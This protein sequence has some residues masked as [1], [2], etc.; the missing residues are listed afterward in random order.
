MMLRR[1]TAILSVLSF[2]L[3]MAGIASATNYTITDL[4]TLS[5]GTASFATGVNSS[6]TVVGFAD[7]GGKNRAAYYQNGVWTNIGSTKDANQNTFFTAI[8]DSGLMVGWDRTSSLAKLGDSF[9]YQVG[10]SITS[11]GTFSGVLNGQPANGNKNRVG[12]FNNYTA[13]GVNWTGY[14]GGINNNGQI[15]GYWFNSSDTATGH[16]FLMSG[17]STTE[18]SV[19]FPSGA[20]SQYC[21]GLNDAGVTIGSYLTNMA[22]TIGWY[23]DGTRH[24]IPYGSVPT[25]IVGNYVVGNGASG[26]FLYTLGA[27][28]PTFIGSL[29]G[30]YNGNIAYGVTSGGVVVGDSFNGSAYRAFLYDGTGSYD[31]NNRVAGTNPFSVLQTASAISS[32]GKYIVGYGTVGSQNHAFLLT[33]VA[34]PEPSTLLLAASGLV[35]LVAYAWR[36]RK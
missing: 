5:G 4:G 14:T 22:A 13:S 31:L 35:G 21:Y 18:V 24:D 33:A 26:A 25:A 36:K 6:G 23:F 11:L 28:S 10:G 8:N 32:N 1:C 20:S 16:A 12:G 30:G 29:G 19:A 34:A 27:G 17:G 2:V 7:A 9:T 15:A 3:L